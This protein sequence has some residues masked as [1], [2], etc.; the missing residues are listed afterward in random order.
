MLVNG[1]QATGVF[2]PI[3]KWLGSGSFFNVPA[4]VIVSGLVF[5]VVYVL[6]NLTRWGRAF[7]AVGGNPIAAAAVGIRVQ[8]YR[9]LAYIISGR[10]LRSQV[11]CWPLAP[12]AATSVWEMPTYYKPFR[13]RWSASQ[14][15]APIKANAF[16][17]LIGAVFVATLINGLTMFNFRTT[18]RTLSRERCWLS[19]C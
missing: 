4:S 16:G 2:A 3:F 1:E 9:A 7:Y 14:S 18:R 12:I 11:C 5:I 6:L 8:K 17:T 10:L 13:R 15:S 19:H